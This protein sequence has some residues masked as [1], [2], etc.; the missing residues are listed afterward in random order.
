MRIDR[1]VSR[2]PHQLCRPKNTSDHLARLVAKPHAWGYEEFST[3]RDSANERRLTA[4]HSLGLGNDHWSGP[5]SRRGLLGIFETAGR[6]N[7][8]RE[9]HNKRLISVA[10]DVG[11]YC[12]TTTLVP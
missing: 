2:K 3:L 1:C 7:P 4:D 11:V 10:R 9:L 12:N 6:R 8:P 5:S